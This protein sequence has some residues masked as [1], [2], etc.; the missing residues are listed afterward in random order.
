MWIGLGIVAALVIGFFVLRSVMSSKMDSDYEKNKYVPLRRWAWEMQLS[1]AEEAA[2]M[3]GLQAYEGAGNSLYINHEDAL[4]KTYERPMV[5]SLFLLGARFRALGPNALANPAEAVKHLLEGFRAREESGVVHLQ[6]PW[7]SEEVDGMNNDQFTTEARKVL[8]SGQMA[9]LDGFDGWSSDEITGEIR[10]RVL[11][12]APPAVNAV[13]GATPYDQEQ[14]AKS[15]AI[16][17]LVLDLGRLLVQ[18][19]ALRASR[20]DLAPPAALRIVL[21]ETL[22]RSAPG[23]GWSQVTASPLQQAIVLASVEGRATLQG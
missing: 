12:H 15:Y 7:F 23:I 10:M 21:V 18:Y 20:H 5:V 6:S 9:G 1:D 4:L 16:N 8:E 2:L 17:T 11:A 22:S 19:R 14:Y 13:Q 3:Q